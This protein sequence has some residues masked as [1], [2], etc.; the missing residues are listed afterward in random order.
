MQ[1]RLPTCS[2]SSVKEQ[3]LQG[4]INDGG[5]CGEVVVDCRDREFTR[6][7]GF[8]RMQGGA[9]GRKKEQEWN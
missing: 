2:N 6:L 4:V 1:M 9:K 5:V 7:L 8:K 3:A